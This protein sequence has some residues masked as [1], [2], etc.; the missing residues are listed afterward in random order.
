MGRPAAQSTDATPDRAT[1]S[2][3]PLAE[4][5]LDD[6]SDALPL[7]SVVIPARNEVTDIERAIEAVA[8]QSYP[9]DRI[10]VI[11]IDGNSTD[12]TRTVARRALEH[13]HWHRAVVLSNPEATTP[14]NLN[15]GLT[16]A[17]GTYLCR[18]DAR[19]IIPTDYVEGCV[20]ILQS[21]PEVAVVGGSQRAIPRDRSH[22]S[23]G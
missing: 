3:G 11:V 19:S 7:V 17:L 9:T 4:A 20:A 14:S 6:S 1:G 21:R 23:T 12:E 8:R 10:E 15:I 13:T 22:L 18:V 16:E 5:G 2:A